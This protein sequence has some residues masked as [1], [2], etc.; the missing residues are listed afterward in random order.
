MKKKLKLN[1]DRCEN[2]LSQETAQVLTEKKRNR[3]LMP[4][5]R[6]DFKKLPCDLAEDILVYSTVKKKQTAARGFYYQCMNRYL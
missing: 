4:S 1:L 3:D 6:K 2:N 5:F